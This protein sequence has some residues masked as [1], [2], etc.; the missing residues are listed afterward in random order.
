MER[1]RPKRELSKAVERGPKRA[2]KVARKTARMQGTLLV[3]MK[4]G[5]MALEK[6]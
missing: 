3:I 6:P 5:K 1:N 2:Y 4:D